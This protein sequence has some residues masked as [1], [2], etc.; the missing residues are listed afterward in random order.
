MM[1]CLVLM[2]P[3]G[4][5]KQQ[6][7]PY[8]VL[9]PEMFRQ[10]GDAEGLPGAI[11]AAVLEVVDMQGGHFGVG[12]RDMISGETVIEQES[13]RFNVP[14]PNLVPTAYCLDMSD[15]GV[16]DPDSVVSRDETIWNALDLIQN[17]PGE[18]TLRVLQILGIERIS[19]WLA[20]SGFEDTEVHGIAHE[21]EGAPTYDPNLTTP[22]ETL[23]MLEIIHARMDR[24]EVVGIVSDPDLP[25]G[26]LEGLGDVRVYGWV[27]AQG[28]A[29][30][31]QLIAVTGD[32]GAYGIALLADELT[33][34]AV[35][36]EALSTILR[37][38]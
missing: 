12:V 25:E 26:M 4:S 6:T 2:A 15:L 21:W 27:S 5:A 36:D 23:E 28:D 10:E 8:F 33:S 22:E 35:A 24:P 20:D 16:V 18:Q 29:K 9:D 32:G 37:S 11:S 19:Q 7:L 3:S 30:S 38:L 13:G 34:P 31:Y 17:T 14:Y 1:M